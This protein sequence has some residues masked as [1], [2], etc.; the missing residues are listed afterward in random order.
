MKLNPE[1]KLNFEE[2]WEVAKCTA[3]LQQGEL[4]L[5]NCLITTIGYQAK[6]K[7]HIEPSDHHRQAVR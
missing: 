4:V 7:M 2:L 5:S 1:S 3:E 6:N